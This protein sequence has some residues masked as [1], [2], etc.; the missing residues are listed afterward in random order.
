[1]RNKAGEKKEATL[2]VPE[3][4]A[5]TASAAVELT[6]RAAAGEIQPG[7]WTPA[8]AFGPDLILEIP[9]VE[10]GVQLRDHQTSS[11]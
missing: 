6:L 9:G 8:G 2:E 1:V 4:Y 11:V 5:L 7:A 10:R 3:G